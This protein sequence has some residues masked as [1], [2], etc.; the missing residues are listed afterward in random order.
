MRF[1][2]TQEL[3]YTID[4]ALSTTF[5]VKIKDFHM[6]CAFGPRNVHFAQIW[7]SKRC[8]KRRQICKNKQ[9]CAVIFVARK[10]TARMVI[11]LKYGILNHRKSTRDGAACLLSFIE[12]KEVVVMSMYE[13]LDLLIAAIGTLIALASMLIALLA[14]LNNRKKK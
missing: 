2:R 11:K 13:S 14:F 8:C 1:F 3:I 12:W 4:M 10:M 6:W 5:F 9:K 7:R